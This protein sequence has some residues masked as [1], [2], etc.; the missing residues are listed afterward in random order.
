M[1]T[2]GAQ[3][4][5]NIQEFEQVAAR[6]FAQLYQS[7]PELAYI[8]Q[9]AIA[10]AMG[11]DEQ[12]WNSY[13]SASGRSLQAVISLTIG[14][15]AAEGYIKAY[16]DYPA[17]RVVLTTRGFAAMKAVPSGL[18]QTVG[19]T[20]VQAAQRGSFEPSK[21][22]DLIGRVIAGFAKEIGG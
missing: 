2:A 7:F 17:A 10:V 11:A 12:N 5:L 13:T 3:E 20:L 1:N 8:D 19:T 9:R 4:P 21:L 18:G 15:L 14:W 6:V 22:G 16:G